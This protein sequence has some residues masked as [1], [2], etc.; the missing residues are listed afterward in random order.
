MKLSRKKKL[1]APTK[2]TKLTV[3][4]VVIYNPL[5]TYECKIAAVKELKGQ[6]TGRRNNK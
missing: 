6:L 5:K 3:E 1:N 2:K 4:A